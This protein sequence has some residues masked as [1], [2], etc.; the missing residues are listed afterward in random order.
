MSVYVLDRNKVLRYAK[1]G[2]YSL[3]HTY[4]SPYNDDD[5]IVQHCIHKNPQNYIHASN[6]LKKQENMAICAIESKTI[7]NRNGFR[8]LLNEFKNN[9]KIVMKSI[10]ID[11]LSLGYASEEMRDNEEICTIAVQKKPETYEF[12]SNRLKKNKKIISYVLNNHEIGISYQQLI[13]F[14]PKDAIDDEIAF[15]LVKKNG[16]Y[17]Y[18]LST[19]YLEDRKYVLEASKTNMKLLE[20]IPLELR[21]DKEIIINI[22]LCNSKKYNTVY[23][24]QF[25]K[26]YNLLFEKLKYDMDIVNIA[27]K[28]NGKY[29][30]YADDDTK[31]NINIIGNAIKTCPEAIIYVSDRIKNSYEI[32]SRLILINFKI[33]KYLNDKYLDDDELAMIIIIN[34]VQLFEYS[35]YRI[36]SNPAF[37]RLAI[38]KNVSSFKFATDVIKNNRNFIDRLLLISTYSTIIKYIPDVILNDEDFMISIIKKNI[39]NIEYLPY[40]LQNNVEFSIKVVSLFPDLYNKFTYNVQNNTK[41]ILCVYDKFDEKNKIKYINKINTNVNS[42][43]NI[44]IKYL[45]KNNELYAKDYDRS[46]ETF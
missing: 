17:I 28:Y 6:R 24:A 33:Y 13:S 21:N 14:I 46:I 43:N 45:V 1:L 26:N 10:S 29:L 25:T 34:Q 32:I 42:A 7:D 23:E 2:Y 36:R 19:K 18:K 16:L 11:P 3:D 38:S 5:V 30:K 15:M 22:L 12:I 37:V 8:Y 9:Y 27:L 40:A 4:M 31:N 44:F 39:A 20:F 41:F 35:S